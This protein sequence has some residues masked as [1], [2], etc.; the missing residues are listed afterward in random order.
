MVE[1][2]WIAI[3]QLATNGRNARFAREFYS[4]AT[5]FNPEQHGGLDCQIRQTACSFIERGLFNESP[6]KNL[7]LRRRRLLPRA[8]SIC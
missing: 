1:I 6:S 3:N 8:F 7:D 5:G 4:V 2:C